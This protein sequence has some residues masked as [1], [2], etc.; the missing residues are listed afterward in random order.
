MRKKN[1]EI[2]GKKVMHKVPHEEIIHIES[3]GMNTFIHTVNG[4]RIKCCKNIGQIEKELKPKYFFRTHTSYIVN[5]KKIR[6]FEKS[7]GGLLVMTNY[8]VIPVSKRR[9]SHFLE[10]HKNF[11]S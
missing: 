9:K 7:K 8:A 10:A 2:N 6:T 11:S 3:K 5:L 4:E 1:L